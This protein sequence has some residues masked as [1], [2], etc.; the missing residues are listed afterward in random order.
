MPW[1]AAGAH[2]LLVDL[3]EHDALAPQ[4]VNRLPQLLVVRQRLV[5]LLQRL[6]HPNE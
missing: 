2:Q 6:Q 1:G 5:E 4:V 3:V